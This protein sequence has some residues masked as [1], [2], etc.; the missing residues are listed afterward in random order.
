MARERSPVLRVSSC[1]AIVPGVPAHF[2]VNH[3][4]NLDMFRSEH[5]DRMATESSHPCCPSEDLAPAVFVILR[6]PQSEE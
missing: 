5:H 2:L 6:V 3:G 4:F 1:H